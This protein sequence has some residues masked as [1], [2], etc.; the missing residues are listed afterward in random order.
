MFKERLPADKSKSAGGGGRRGPSADYCSP[1]SADGKIYQF[2]KT[3][4][5]YVIEAKPEFKVLAVNSLNDGSEF[6]ST[7]AISEG[8][9]YV[10]SNKNLYCIAAQ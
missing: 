7:P 1:V 9:I 4:T 5:C 8:K 3:G 2:A 10:R 6:N